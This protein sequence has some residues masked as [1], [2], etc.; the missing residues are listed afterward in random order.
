MDFADCRAEPA[1]ARRLWDV[2]GAN[3]LVLCGLYEMNQRSI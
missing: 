1:Q 2:T 3:R